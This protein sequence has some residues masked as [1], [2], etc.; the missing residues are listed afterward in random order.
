MVT[1]PQL[2]WVPVLPVV[3]VLLCRSEHIVTTQVRYHPPHCT[4]DESFT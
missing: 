2:L 4:V 1:V 3:A